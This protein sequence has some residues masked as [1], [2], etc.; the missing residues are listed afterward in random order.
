MNDYSLSFF[1]FFFFII[2]KGATDQAITSAYLKKYP[3]VYEI[4]IKHKIYN[5]FRFWLYF[6]DGIWQSIVVFFSFYFVYGTNPNAH[7]V[8][9]SGLQLST[10]VAVTAIVIANMMPGFNTYYW[11]WWQFV[12]IFIELLAVF[13]WVVIYGA[14]KSVSMYGMAYMV[15]GEWSFWLTFFVTIVVAFLPRFLCCFIVQWWFT[16]VMHHVRHI[17]L[18]D[19]QM[20]KQ[21]NRKFFSCI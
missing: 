1:L 6:A 8:P 16:D 20:K 14:F 2:Y 5:K 4:G 9:E 19:K 18:H 21:R 12:F 15:F 10:S 7:G 11:T 17:E 3:Q 13:L